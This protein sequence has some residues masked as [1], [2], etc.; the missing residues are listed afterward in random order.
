M[1]SLQEQRGLDERAGGNSPYICNRLVHH[2]YR[3]RMC[4]H[5]VSQSDM[6]LCTLNSQRQRLW[7]EG[8]CQVMQRALLLISLGSE[9]ERSGINL[10]NNFPSCVDGENVSGLISSF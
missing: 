1:T 3:N 5:A 10:N 4:A 7:E 8:L 2:S 6:C 9:Q